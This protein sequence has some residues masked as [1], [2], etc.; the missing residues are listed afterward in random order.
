MNKLLTLCG[1]AVLSLATTANATT[2]DID[3]AHTFVQLRVQH[4]GYSWL[5]GRF[6]DV[7]GS[8]FFDP[9]AGPAA[10]KIDI[11]VKTTS[12]DTNHAE[13]DKHLR[14]GDFLNV[15]EYPTASFVSTGYEGGPDG[16]FMN[17]DLTVHG[18]TLPVRVKI[19]KTGEGP[20]PWGGYRAGFEGEVA[21][22]SREVGI[23]QPL[24]PVSELVEITVYVEG[25][26]R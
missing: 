5:S 10:Q 26:R 22:M 14:S 17:G 24:G 4:L 13:R 8:F 23:D 9:A 2:Y 6:N 19:S 15:S 25:I 7:E 11:S 3:P 16:G 18:V 12:I 20:D 21:V 1:L